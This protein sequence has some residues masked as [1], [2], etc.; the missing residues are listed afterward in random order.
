MSVCQRSTAVIRIKGGGE[1]GGNRRREISSNQSG[2]RLSQLEGGCG[3][4][5]TV[6]VC[7]ECSVFFLFVHFKH[8]FFS[9][10]F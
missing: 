7:P 3:F 2:S 8:V 1:G 6:V 10:F 4:V 5:K 9:V